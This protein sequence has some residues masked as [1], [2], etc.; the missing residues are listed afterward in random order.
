LKTHVLS[1]LFLVSFFSSDFAHALTGDNKY[2]LNSDNTQIFWKIKAKAEV[3]LTGFQLAADGVNTDDWVLANVPGTVFSSYVKAG[4]ELDPNYSDNINHVV[5]TKYGRAYWYRMQFEVPQEN[6]NDK[7]WINFDGTNKFATFYLNGKKLGYTAGHMF[8]TKFDITSSLNKTGKNTVSVL[9]DI[10]IQRK[11]RAGDGPF[12]IFFN[13]ESPTYIPSASWDWMPFVPGLNTGI[14]DDVYLSFT[15]NVTMED[16][17]IRTL[18]PSNQNAEISI[19]SDIKNSSTEAQTATISGL[20]QPG[21]VPFSKEIQLLGSETK[22]ITIDK[23][24][25]S[26]L[27]I[28]N[29]LLWWPNG[30]GDQNLY[31]CELKC[32][33]GDQQSDIKDITFGIK[34]YEYQLINNVLHFF[35]NGQ[36]LFLKGGNWGMSEYMLR[37]RGKEYDTKIALHKDMNF[38]IIRNWAGSTTDD[39]FYEACDRGGIMIWDDFWLVNSMVTLSPRNVGE[40]LINAKDKIKRVRNHPSLALWCGANESTP[41]DSINNNLKRYITAMDANDRLYQPCSNGKGGLSGS[42]LW[43]NSTPRSYFQSAP[44]SGGGDNGHSANEGY[45]LRSEIG[46]ATFTTFESFKEFMPE[47]NWWPRNEMWNMHY[48]GTNAGNAGPD[49]YFNTVNNQYGTSAEAEEFC[50]KSQM[51]NIETLKGMFEAWN[52]KMWNDASGIIM[53]MSQSAYPSLVWQTYDYYYDATGAY[54]GAKK[55]C[56][57]IHVQWNAYSNDIKVINTTMQDYTNVTVKATMYNIDGSEYTTG[58]KT[59]VVNA[60]ASKATNCFIVV[61]ANRLKS[62]VN[63]LKLELT[64]QNGQLLSDNYY[65]RGKTPYLFT[66]LDTLPQVDLEFETTEKTENGKY[67]ID[68]KITNPG[69]SPALAFPVRLRV[70]NS[71]TRSRILP[72]FMSDNYML[73]LKNETKNVHIEFDEALL[74]GDK[75]ELLAKQFLKSELQTGIKEI[76]VE[77]SLLK[78]YPNP[79]SGIA[80][81]EY[82][83]EDQNINLFNIQGEKVYSDFGKKINIEKLPQGFYYVQVSNGKMKWTVKIIKK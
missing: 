51:L 66:S 76:D 4:L 26:Q 59:A 9:I 44:A 34:K 58:A 64:D 60:P 1:F 28:L 33:V 21:N 16:P 31:T 7:I 24:D 23:N 17:W 32:Y 74:G 78:V 22:S 38:N 54:W 46:T 56:E 65:W 83:G 41:V 57:P 73:I 6:I 19:S 40:F 42:G 15:G 11:T 82:A 71:R 70:V 47:E 55:A 10:P 79:T 37:C 62:L 39:E 77:K 48:F 81:F 20:I 63:I 14:T 12:D 27:S 61:A 50:E 18:L 35:I 45:G 43:T 49:N 25:C 68:A 75:P 72:V 36:K 67:I 5:D 30:Y 80:Y 53:W 13:T 29:P 52:D 8:R 69:T 3:S 2:S